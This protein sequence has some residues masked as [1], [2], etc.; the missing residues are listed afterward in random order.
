MLKI[1][2]SEILPIVF[3]VLL[4]F[5]INAQETN[6]LLHK[7][8]TDKIST[9]Q[10]EY[11]LSFSPDGEELFF[12]RSKGQWGQGG[13]KS[14]IYTSKRIDG[15]WSDPMLVPFSSNYD[16]G[17][18]HLSHDGNTLF[19]VSD[20]PS[21]AEIQSQ[22]IWQ[23]QRSESGEWA[24]PERLLYPINT[25]QRE[26]SPRTDK[27]GNLYFASDRAGGL[28][29]GDIYMTLSVAG[30]YSEPT[31]LG[32]PINTSTGEWNLEINSD[33]DVMIVE[34]SERSE[35]LSPYGDLYISFKSDNEWSAPQNLSEINT[36]GSDLYPQIVQDGKFLY[37]TSSDS[38]RSTDT[39]IYCIEFKDMLE[40]YRQKAVFP[41]E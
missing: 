28:G 14:S 1:P 18:P 27:D 8:E 6:L 7:F 24:A 9:D 20:R 40:A 38:L 3:F 16:D 39:N 17:D 13:M 25:E 4:G 11:S 37:Y 5:H 26:Y 19:F 30:Q 12:A 33:G 41:K 29:Q 34:A 21:G 2:L 32:A 10:V 31:N 23:V 15:V 22:D 36:T 35:N